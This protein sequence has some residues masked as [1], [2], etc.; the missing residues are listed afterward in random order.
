MAKRKQGIAF[1]NAYLTFNEDTILITEVSKDSEE[2]FDL[3]KELRE[4]EGTEGLSLA[5]GFDKDIIP[6]G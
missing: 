2:T 5:V 3:I 4:L 6:I 1:K